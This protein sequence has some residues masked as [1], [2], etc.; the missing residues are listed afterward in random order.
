MGVQERSGYCGYGL[1]DEPTNT[2]SD[3][4]IVGDFHNRKVLKDKRLAFLKELPKIN[5]R[6]YTSWEAYVNELKNA[7]LIITGRQH[8][9]FAACSARLPF[10]TFAGNTH[11]VEGFLRMADVRI[12]VAETADELLQAIEFAKNNQGEF[13]KLFDYLEKQDR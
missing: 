10:A 7:K 8:E 5:I 13:D 11:K 12:P 1:A 4:I 2:Y 3:Q 6:G 9:V